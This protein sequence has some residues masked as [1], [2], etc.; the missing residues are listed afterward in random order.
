MSN[1]IKKVAYRVTSIALLVVSVG[2]L[3]HFY[4]IGFLGALVLAA[5]LWSASDIESGTA[6]R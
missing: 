4:A 3:V 5:I 6:G 1:E 2:L